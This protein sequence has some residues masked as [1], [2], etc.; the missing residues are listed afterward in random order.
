[1]HHYFFTM[2]CFLLLTTNIH[3]TEK[4]SLENNVSALIQIILYHF[5]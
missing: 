2:I 3:F 1:M 4:R 5:L